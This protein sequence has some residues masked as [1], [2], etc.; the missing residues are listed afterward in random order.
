MTKDAIMRHALDLKEAEEIV[1]GVFIGSLVDGQSPSFA[2]KNKIHAVINCTKDLPDQRNL[3]PLSM[4]IPVDDDLTKKEID[5]LYNFLPQG[6][7]MIHQCVDAGKNVL[8]HCFAGRQ[9]SAAVTCAYLMWRYNCRL[10][11]AMSLI[12]SKKPDAFTPTANFLPALARF[13]K[14]LFSR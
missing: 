6:V 11:R 4:R 13:E 7:A 2:R 14:N 10:P 3:A 5:A 9:R 8:V 12:R 1:P